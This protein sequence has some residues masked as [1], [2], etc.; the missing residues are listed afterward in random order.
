MT[1]SAAAPQGPG[2]P[3]RRNTA[4]G[5][6]AAMA[7]AAIAGCTTNTSVRTVEA[8]QTRAEASQ[9]APD[10]A[11]LRRRATTRLELAAG[12]FENGQTAVAQEEARRAL[13]IDPRFA[14]AHNLG[15]LIAMRLGDLAAAEQSFRQAL[16]LDPDNADLQHNYGWLL[17]QRQQY[18][19]AQALFGRAL[20]HPTYGGKAKTLMA[21]GLCQVRAGSPADGEASLKR[22]FMLD[23]Q[24]P[25]TKYTLADLL[26]R[27]GAL[28]DARF[29]IRQLN[30]GDF[31]NA[32]SLWLGIR[33]ERRLGDTLAM[34][35]LASQLRKRFPQSAEMA[36]FDRGAFDE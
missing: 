17:C 9:P 30:N 2:A 28:E 8:S 23:T 36:S 24:N 19:Q 34:Q 13:A 31:A 11:E 22:S 27:R 1:L 25:V 7:L 16:A 14:E 21:Q 29:Y 12:Y 35:Q 6:L 4:A 20:A 33:I 18:A 3:K 10:A 15:G 5:M 32:E 26:Q